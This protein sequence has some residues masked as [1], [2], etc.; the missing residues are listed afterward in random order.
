MGVVVTACV[1]TMINSCIVGEFDG[2]NG[3][4]TIGPHQRITDA[5][6]AIK[7]N[8]KS[9][10]SSFTLTLTV[11]AQ[12]AFSLSSCT[13]NY[14]LASVTVMAGTSWTPGQIPVNFTGLASCTLHIQFSEASADNT[15]QVGYFNGVSPP[16]HRRRVHTDVSMCVS[17]GYC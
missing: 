17:S 1:L 8:L 7:A 14:D 4:I 15:L 2:F 13:P 9:G 3:Y 11:T 10:G 16:P 6:A 5:P 12:N